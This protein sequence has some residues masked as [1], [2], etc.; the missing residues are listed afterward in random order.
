M[1]YSNTN[2]FGTPLAEN[3]KCKINHKLIGKFPYFNF[4][5]KC[6][7]EDTKPFKGANR[8]VLRC[9]AGELMKSF[10]AP[11]SGSTYMA[12]FQ[13]IFDFKEF[14]NCLWSAV[15]PSGN[16]RLILEVEKQTITNFTV[17]PTLIAEG[18]T[19]TW[20]QLEV[21]YPGDI[22]KAYFK[23]DGELVASAVSTNTDKWDNIIRIGYCPAVET[24]FLSL[25]SNFFK[26]GMC[27]FK[28]Y[29]DDEL[30][31][32]LPL[33]TYDPENGYGIV[34]EDKVEEYDVGP[35]LSQP[36]IKR[37]NS[38]INI[39]TAYG[40]SENLG[41]SYNLIYGYKRITSSPNS[42][43]AG[44]YPIKSEPSIGSQV[45]I[46]VYPGLSAGHNGDPDISIDLTNSGLPPDTLTKFD[47]KEALKFAP[48][49]YYYCER[50]MTPDYNI[51]GKQNI[52]LYRTLQTGQSK[53]FLE[54]C[55]AR[56]VFIP[57]EER[58][59]AWEMTQEIYKGENKE[60]QLHP[61]VQDGMALWLDGCNNSKYGHYT[62]TRIWQDLAPLE[63]NSFHINNQPFKGTFC[64]TNKGFRKFI[65]Y[66]LN[67]VILPNETLYDSTGNLPSKIDACTIEM[68]FTPL[69]T[70]SS[71][72][73]GRDLF[74]L[75]KIINN[76]VSSY[77]LILKAISNEGNTLRLLVGTGNNTY[78]TLVL[79]KQFGDM[80]F[81]T[82]H[83]AIT[84]GSG[85][86]GK[87]TA[88]LNGSRI[89]TSNKPSRYSWITTTNGNPNYFEF[90]HKPGT[91]NSAHEYFG[92]VHS[93]R[94]YDRE[95]TATEVNWNYKEDN[96]RYF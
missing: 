52:K 36:E 86:S 35:F 22:T 5:S 33:Q 74:H 57:Y 19:D 3:T 43:Y 31:Y 40:S 88:Y 13:G 2:C 49:E 32:H 34:T 10:T 24:S 29:K 75:G 15:D 50:V 37:Y 93:V 91:N 17:L 87:I 83:I 63:K 85:T 82:Y 12:W 47:A 30:L 27:D 6:Y 48:S 96:R 66:Y 7:L 51:V 71:S 54:H 77:N 62:N 58:N 80:R 72:G 55:M 4:S 90:L 9:S 84:I 64:W 25:E 14:G 89:Y 39:Q 8:V 44:K 26:G 18:G 38:S 11:A 46:L 92:D 45:E 95:L 76:D 59:Q 16:K 70:F 1:N 56:N 23:F 21:Y 78:Q 79:K 41:Y 69:Q 42:Y 94:Y 61:Y 81:K 28:V 53:D 65:D 67:Q 73:Y 60:Y 20:H 68:T